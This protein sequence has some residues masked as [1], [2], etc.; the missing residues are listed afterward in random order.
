M[1]LNKQYVIEQLVLIKYAYLKV[2]NK[3]HIE[4][5]EVLDK[6]MDE[7]ISNYIVHNTYAN[8]KQEKLLK[9]ID[10]YVAKTVG[11]GWDE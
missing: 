1:L 2:I 5:A 4:W 10:Y 7:G 8:R 3:E 9:L 6:N 11:N